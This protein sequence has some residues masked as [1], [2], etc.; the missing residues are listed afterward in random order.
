MNTDA[1]D[2]FFELCHKAK[3]VCDRNPSASEWLPSFES[4][5]AHLRSNGNLRSKFEDAFIKIIDNPDLAPW[6]LIAYCMH[7]LQWKR[8]QVKVLDNMASSCDWRIKTIM[9]H[10]LDSFNDDWEDRVLY[11]E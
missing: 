11:S 8:V 6:E 9:S 7:F 2:V 5:L 1:I 3:N 10:I 4:V